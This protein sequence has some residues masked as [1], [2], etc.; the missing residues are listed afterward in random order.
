M[1]LECIQVAGPEHCSC[2]ANA[3]P[4]LRRTRYEFTRCTDGAFRGV[5]KIWLERV[6]D[7][8]ST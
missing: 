6:I 1:L 7:P 8:V 5:M 2:N 3:A 4:S